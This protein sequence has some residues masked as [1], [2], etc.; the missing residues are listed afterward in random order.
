MEIQVN[1]N[2]LERVVIK[3]LNQ[4]YGN[5]TPKKHKDHPNSVFYVISNNDVMMEYDKETN[6][7]WIDKEVIWLMIGSLF[8]LNYDNTQS[9]MKVWLRD[10]YKLGGVTPLENYTMRHIRWKSHI[11]WNK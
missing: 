7:V 8:N 10:T 9:I 3:W 5:L 2:Q 4:H 6:R 1:S 11:N